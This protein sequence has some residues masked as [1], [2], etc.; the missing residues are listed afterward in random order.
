MT[1]SQVMLF[2]QG[3]LKEH[4]APHTLLQDP[5]SLFSKLVDD[6]GSAANHL[7][8]LAEEGANARK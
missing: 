1:F 4:D 2:D 8:A 5:E 7:R 6:A 3:A